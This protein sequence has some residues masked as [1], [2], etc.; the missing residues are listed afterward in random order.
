[1]GKVVYTSEA[2]L[3]TWR[4]VLPWMI[5]ADLMRHRHLIATMTAR[6]FRATYQASHFGLAWQVMLPLIM[7]AVFYLVFGRILGG[8]FS[9]AAT[10]A[11]VDYALALFVG[12]GI[13]TFVSQNIGNAPSL[14]TS[15]IGYVKSLSFP[16]ELLSIT[17]VLTSGL[18]LV[19]SLGL[20]MIVMLLVK[21]YLH[22]SVV[23]LPLYV[24][25]A[26][27]LSLGLS[28]GLSAIAVFIRDVAAI[29]A[30]VTLILMFMCPIFYP[31]SMV[32]KQIKWVVDMNPIAVIIEDGRACLLYGV[33]PTPLSAGIL[34]L[35]SLAVATVGYFI[36]MR[37]K[38]AFADVM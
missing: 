35:V 34:F 38:A 32:P 25:C 8:R 17:S 29:V 10:E 23:C 11:P 4:Q 18:T 36:F 16:L 15:N 31:A 26:F 21:G 22:W 28:W 27:L 37:S 6:D 24:I 33:W 5:L 13:F 19:I 9:N 20:T 2:K 30:P 3:F 12:L 7:L 1:M 14:I